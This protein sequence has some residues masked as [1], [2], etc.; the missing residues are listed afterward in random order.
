[1]TSS[2]Y[3]G[4]LVGNVIK[5]ISRYKYKGTPEEDISKAIFYLTELKR[6]FHSQ[7]AAVASQNSL[8]NF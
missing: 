2:E 3:E 5:Y 7:Q 4:F 6:F 8:N 1:M